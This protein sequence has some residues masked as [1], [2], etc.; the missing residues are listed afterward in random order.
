MARAWVFAK[1]QRILRACATEHAQ[2]LDAIREQYCR[3]KE[4]GRQLRRPL[5]RLVV[6]FGFFL[7]D[8]LSLFTGLIARVVMVFSFRFFARLLL[9]RILVVGH[10][11]L[12]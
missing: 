4:K 12:L 5:D 2:M 10:L 1:A 11:V 7:G 3:A 8:D 9:V 6:L